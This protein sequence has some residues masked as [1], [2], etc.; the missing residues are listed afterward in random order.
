VKVSICIIHKKVPFFLFAPFCPVFVSLTLLKTKFRVKEPSIL[1]LF[2]D[3]ELLTSFGYTT[4]LAE[5]DLGFP[6]FIDDL[7]WTV[8]LFD[9]LP[10]FLVSLS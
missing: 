6:K 8:P 2:G 3:T 4:P 5:K 7:L 9:H 1:R 10:P